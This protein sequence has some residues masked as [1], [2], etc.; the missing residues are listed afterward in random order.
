M[1]LLIGA[2]I[3]ALIIQKLWTAAR[4]DHELAKQGKISPRLEAKYGAGAKA[5]VEQYGFTDFLR[6]A[7][8][9]FWSRRGDALVAA[10]DAPPAVPGERVRFRDRVA[11]ARD[12]VVNGVRKAAASPVVRKLV[13]PVER[14]QKD[15]APPQP[16]PEIPD[17]TRDADL[18]PGTR[19]IGPDG[20]YEE[21]DGYAWRPANQTANRPVNEPATPAQPAPA[22]GTTMT[23][24]TGEAVNYETTIAELNDLAD[25]Q[26]GHLDQCQAALQAIEAAKASIGDM[27]DSYRASATAAANISDHLAARNLDGVTLA[28]AGTT[29]DAMPAGKVDEM[30]DQLEVMEADAK[31]RLADAEIALGATEENLRH[32]QATYGDA[33]ET[34]AGQLGGDSS[35]LDSGGMSG[36]GAGN[37]GS[38]S[39]GA[40][41]ESLGEHHLRLADGYDPNYLTPA[42]ERRTG[43]A[44]QRPMS[45]NGSPGSAPVPTPGPGHPG[46]PST[47]HVSVGVERR[48][49]Q[50]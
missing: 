42:A 20:G 14:R 16:D 33:H 34:V 5:K 13:D 21:W 22:G 31:A 43:A 23:A 29:V 30:F 9:D 4:T 37:G 46:N 45:P 40:G 25:Q 15:T 39:F 47:T 36:T 3:Y 27:Q 11:A 44:T 28:N 48:G 32:I 17:A 26:R 6:D 1:E 50:V 19:R 7:Y 10:R 35:F 38:G 12:V 24:S 18:P 8:H 41:G 2:A 49:E